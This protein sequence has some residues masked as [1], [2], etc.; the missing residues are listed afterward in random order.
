MV[1]LQHT[2]VVSVDQFS[3]PRNRGTRTVEDSDTSLMW[4]WWR[5]FCRNNLSSSP[6]TTLNDAACAPPT[7]AADAVRQSSGC[8]GACLHESRM[9]CVPGR[10]SMRRAFMRRAGE[11]QALRTAAARRSAHWVDGTEAHEG[12][13]FQ[14]CVC[15]R[16]IHTICS[17]GEQDEAA[18][19]VAV[20]VV[21][22]GLVGRT[23]LCGIQTFSR[24]TSP[25]V[26][27]FQDCRGF[28]QRVGGSGSG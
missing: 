6:T 17:L 22:V 5:F 10:V 4:W 15:S 21:R 19:S 3:E 26:R 23:T 28:E 27:S 13:R 20:W 1:I 11:K 14:R 18:V 2:Q 25:P 7:G 24:V 8:V 9:P 16:E 12:E